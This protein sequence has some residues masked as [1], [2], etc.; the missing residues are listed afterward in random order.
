MSKDIEM[1]KK[2]LNYLAENEFIELKEVSKNNKIPI[3]PLCLY[4]NC[5]R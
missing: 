2:K 5:H 1:V 4:V 3:F